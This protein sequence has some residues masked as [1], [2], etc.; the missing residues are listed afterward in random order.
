MGQL[1]K[2][3]LQNGKYKIHNTSE[4]D[5]KYYFETKRQSLPFMCLKTF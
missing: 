3:L 1:F 4:A 2:H 5:N